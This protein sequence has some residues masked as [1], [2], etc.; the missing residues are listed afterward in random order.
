MN[1]SENP[2]RP[3]NHISDIGDTLPSKDKR[4]MSTPG[5]VLVVGAVALSAAF[6]GTID[7]GGGE[8]AHK[9]AHEVAGATANDFMFN[10]APST[11]YNAANETIQDPSGVSQELLDQSHELY[12]T[13]KNETPTSVLNVVTVEEGQGPFA[14]VQESRYNGEEV[15]DDVTRM[16]AE[17]YIA[18]QS[19]EPGAEPGQFH[20]GDKVILP[21][22]FDVPGQTTQ[23]MPAVQ[24]PQN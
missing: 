11:T 8:V 24:A 7:K 3:K 2:R 13:F 17:Q 21:P 4:R 22:G 10:H 16:A 23:M 18:A 20:V 14:I 9:A 19:T 6:V 15:T 5:K 12:L 1:P